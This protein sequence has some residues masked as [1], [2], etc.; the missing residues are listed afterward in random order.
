MPARTTPL[1]YQY[2]K[3]STC[4][5][6]LKWLAGRGITHEKV[7]LVAQPPSV[8]VLR[9][10]HRR[11][12]LPVGKL[13]NT[14]GERYRQGRFKERLATLSDA[15]ALAALASDGKLIKRPIVDTGKEVL[16]GF[17]QAA[18]ARALE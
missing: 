5:K 16:V 9:D 3:C 11:S 2:P 17:D 18:Y 4:R 1:V 6:A 14:S 10:L 8:A 12:G 15:E 7:D 13:F